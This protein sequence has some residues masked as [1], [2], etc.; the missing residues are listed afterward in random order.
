MHVLERVERVYLVTLRF[1]LVVLATAAL[2]AAL[3]A[4]IQGFSDATAKPSPVSSHQFVASFLSRVSNAGA[5]SGS[6]SGSVSKPGSQPSR[7]SPAKQRAI[8]KIYGSLYKMGQRVKFPLIGKKKFTK[9]LISYVKANAPAHPDRVLHG[10]SIYVAAVAHDNLLRK[11]L[12]YAEFD[13]FFDHLLNYYA[14]QHNRMQLRAH[15]KRSKSFTVL[16]VAG[17]A[18][19]VFLV[20]ALLLVLAK[21]ERDLDKIHA[22]AAPSRGT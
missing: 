10:L 5:G 1:V 8:N 21:I 20:L 2:L 9:I 22:A 13:S 12:T 4:G 14:G 17:G 18:L 15:Q 7:L 16:S 19:G 3:V 11:N 6:N